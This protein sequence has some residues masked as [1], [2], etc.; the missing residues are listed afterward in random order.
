MKSGGRAATA[1]TA[2]ARHQPALGPAADNLVRGAPLASKPARGVRCF[3]GKPWKE[4]DA[5]LVL[6]NGEVY[7]GYAFGH[8]ADKTYLAEVVFNTSLTGYQEILTDPSY[9][10]QMVRPMRQT[11]GARGRPALSRPPHA[12]TL[13]P[14]PSRTHACGI[15]ATRARE[16]FH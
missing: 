4:H 7:P 10:G 1:A 16:P 14:S 8:T 9:H 15:Q 3:A 12:Y 5:R 6:E 13:P 11:F 2:T